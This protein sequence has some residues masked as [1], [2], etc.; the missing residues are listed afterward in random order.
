MRIE[1][2]RAVPDSSSADPAAGIYGAMPVPVRR[3][4][5]VA[6]ASAVFGIA[7]LA[8][9]L[10]YAGA[11]EV[12]LPQ[13]VDALCPVAGI[14]GIFGP[15]GRSFF[16]RWMRGG[17]EEDDAEERSDTP[18][19]PLPEKP[20]LPDVEV[21]FI[22]TNEEPPEVLRQLDDPAPPAGESPDFPSDEPD[23]AEEAS[24]DLLWFT[25]V[26][27]PDGVEIAA[28][29]SPEHP[30]D[31]ES[32]PR[33]DALTDEELI[34]MLGFDDGDVGFSPGVV[35]YD[36]I[37]PEDEER[38]LELLIDDL[39]SN[40]AG[41][42]G[43]AVTA[44]AEHGADAVEPLVHALARADDGRRWCVAEALA[45]IGEDSIPALIAALGDGATKIGAAATLVRIGRPAVEPLIEA[46]AGDD[47][48]VQ[49]GARY[50]LREIGDEAIPS[51]VEALDA[52]DGS[53]RRSAASVLRELGWQAP[54]DAGAIRYLIAVE[55]WLDVADY[56]EAAV[57]PL[58]RILKSPDKEAW[59]NAA[60]TLGE[61]GEAAVGPLV[62]L[63]H[64][65]D[66]EVRPLAAM[67]LAEIGL[68]AVDPLIRLLS[69]PALGGTAAASLVKIGEPAAE[70]CLRALE[71]ADGEVQETLENVICA[72][73]E[74]AVPYLIQALMSGRSR[75]R[76][77]AAEI[78][79]RMGWEPWSD[80]ERAWYLIAHEEWME[81]ALM[82][83]PAVDPLIRALNGDD[84]RIRGEA[85]ATLG[86]I[87]D[88]AAVGPLVD[89][90]TD[91]AVAPVAADALVAI[92]E[93]AIA[94]VLGMLEEG[95]GN[96]RESA[97][98]V[99]GRLGAPEAVPAIVEL[100]RTGGARLHRKA[101]D[102][103]VGIGAPAVGPLISLL[104][105]DGDGHA[106]AASALTRIGDP[107]L[108]P[109]TE[110]LGSE[111]SLIRM[112]AARVLERLGWS[113]GCIDEQT[114]YLIALQRWPEVVELGA[115]AA[116]HLAVR[117]GDPDPA[118][119]AGVAESLARLG[120]PAVSPLIGLLGE[121][122][123]QESA[124][125]IL[126]RIG[127]GAVE[128]LIRALSGEA[129]RL[130]AAEVLV[131]M[132][133]P[134]AGA[135]VL[136]L[137]HPEIGPTAAEILVMMGEESLDTLVEA[138]GDDDSRIRRR[139]GDVLIS[140]EDA[141][142]DSLIGAL[143]HPNDIIR[144]EAIDTLTRVGRPIVAA[145]T[146]S[147]SD[148]RYLVRLG[149]AEVLGR[150]GWEPAT[151]AETVCYLIA[152]EQ[153]AS[154]AESGAGAVEVLIRTLSDPDTA[155]QMGAA[156]A[157]GM[158]GAPAVTRL[159]DE[160]RSE[161][162]G[163]QRK[164]VEALK[165]IGEPAVVPL[166]G[167]LQ[168]RDW[169]IRLGAARALVG[170]GDPAVE[171]LVRALRDAPPAV[172]MG[173]A[174]TLGKIGNPGAVEPL[175]DALLSEDWRMGRVVVRA[176]GMLGEPAVRPLLR[177]LS[178][179]NDT[180]RKG[181]VAALVLIGEPA[182]RLLPGALTD[183]HFRV[184]AGVADALDRLG[185]SPEPGEETVVYLIAKER[186]GNL[187]SM[188]PAA[189]G[190][191]IA[192]LNDRDDSIRR[193]AAKVLG[194][195]GDPR[196]V[197][198]LIGLLHD[199]YYSIRREAAAALGATGVPAMEPVVSALSDP[200]ADVRKRAAD[201]L[202]EIGDARAIEP[203]EGI[204]D[205]EDWYARMAAGNAVERIR[206]RVGKGK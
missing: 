178:D 206:E 22:E 14:P 8:L 82:G 129:L 181:A 61:V 119:K 146:E 158:I 131:R 149:A 77:R 201:V 70:A 73:G 90:L 170:I 108:G 143:G 197:P 171:P 76:A 98:E 159:I 84:G 165:M 47:G 184:R 139:A 162:D 204:F 52:P 75:T 167:A 103:L 80:A 26:P 113:P 12:Q 2:R 78:L 137:A 5:S 183:G 46:L 7:A 135:L 196:A 59:W 65:A 31:G 200:D 157:L 69:I 179:G 160:L 38:P 58:I 35:G 72:L 121:E 50:A 48:E 136:V 144:L 34:R 16:R 186:W 95:A 11:T 20:V 150:I 180:S 4:T 188:G 109:L 57:E 86:E 13:T 79:G 127:E 100:V 110:A 117:F 189:V 111:H 176:L 145:L 106:G 122:A 85:A 175:I 91:E 147:L 107:A 195:I 151:E 68:P 88:P 191:L 154:V 101:V 94:P 18:V 105:E 172:R 49:F 54:D 114:T 25:D 182:V 205:D 152:K 142:V 104:G 190:P 32:A 3:W 140:L 56:G 6:V 40:D 177:V 156:R 96:A 118:V 174:A 102:A 24:E 138:L 74:P 93:P 134:A 128:P 166:V 185:W 115:P 51:L 124:G 187:L 45:L 44:V 199:D 97:V 33:P 43:R 67:A 27:S 125:D 15:G 19:E 29:E 10:L 194:E 168:D 1:D 123:Y 41:V 36:D 71:S 89:A 133:R 62:D 126:V 83:S 30:S 63:L 28:G 130:A 203:L 164:A 17:A 9:L 60:R 192:V 155:I 81:L 132:G 64:E 112:G 37:P 141:A 21:T 53:T 148:E 42:R 120:S 87:G 92:G 202:S 39:G 66:D 198:A 23:A 161:Q 99:L 153:W 173:A 163:G 55:A 169:Q 193:R 116:D